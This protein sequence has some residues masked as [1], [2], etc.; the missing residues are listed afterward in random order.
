MEQG[1]GRYTNEKG[2]AVEGQNRADRRHLP[3][4]QGH[5]IVNGLPASPPPPTPH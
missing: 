5:H 1:D 2:P 3:L 4:L